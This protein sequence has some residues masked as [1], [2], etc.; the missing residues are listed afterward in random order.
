MSSVWPGETCYWSPFL[1]INIFFRVLSSKKIFL[2]FLN[3]YLSSFLKTKQK[4]LYDYTGIFTLS[5]SQFLI[6]GCVRAHVFMSIVWGKMWGERRQRKKGSVSKYRCC[7]TWSNN[8]WAFEKE[9]RW[10]GSHILHGMFLRIMRQQFE[11][12]LL[13]S[14]KQ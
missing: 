13:D 3:F 1:Y 7:V 11:I 2:I 5:K 9:L 10:T 12:F 4:W 8:T 14:L 6:K